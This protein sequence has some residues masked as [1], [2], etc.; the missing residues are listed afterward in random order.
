LDHT[1]ENN[2][3]KIE[4]IIAGK[5]SGFYLDEYQRLLRAGIVFPREGTVWHLQHQI[6]T[7]IHR[8]ISNNIRLLHGLIQ[9]DPNIFKDFKIPGWK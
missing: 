3:E 6:G 7:K 5:P 4:E 1:C 8:C 9:F 2:H